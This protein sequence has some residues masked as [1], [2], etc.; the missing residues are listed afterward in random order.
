VR[1]HDGLAMSSRNQYLTEVDRHKALAISRALFGA[2]T[3]YTQGVRQTNR[4]MASMQR[5]LLEQHLS[6]DYIAAVDAVS[7]KP[8]QVIETPTVLAIAAR[9]GVTRLIDNIVVGGDGR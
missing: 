4:L 5:V 1:E 3:E 9:V 6:V 8:V 7:L 2:K